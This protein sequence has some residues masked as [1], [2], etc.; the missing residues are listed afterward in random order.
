MLNVG[1]GKV[2]RRIRVHR[3]GLQHD[4]YEYGRLRLDLLL[5]GKLVHSEEAGGAIVLESRAVLDGLLRGPLLHIKLYLPP[6]ERRQPPSESGLRQQ[7]PELVL[8]ADNQPPSVVGISRW[9]S[10]SLLGLRGR[11]HQ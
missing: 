3:D 11:S 6:A 4:L 7:H 9:G 8:L 1:F 5:L 2:V 10:V